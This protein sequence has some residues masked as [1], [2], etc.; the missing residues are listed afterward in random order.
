MEGTYCVQHY[1]CILLINTN[2]PTGTRTHTQQNPYP[3]AG[4][5]FLPG[6]GLGSPEKPK[7]YPLQCLPTDHFGT[8]VLSHLRRGFVWQRPQQF[9]LWFVR[10]NPILLVEE[11]VFD[12]AKG[13]EPRIEKHAVMPNIIVACVHAPQSMSRS[14][15]VPSLLRKL[16]REALRVLRSINENSRVF[17]QLLL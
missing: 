9:L 13:M 3:E 8:I 14:G 16:M 10:K 5:G 15:Q 7:G 6:Q 2:N 17:D 4:Y 11:L 12:G 1:I